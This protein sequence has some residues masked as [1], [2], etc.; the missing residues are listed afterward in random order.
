MCNTD[1]LNPRYIEEA[2]AALSALDV[3][4]WHLA[5]VDHPSPVPLARQAPPRRLVL[6]DPDHRPLAGIPLLWEG[7][8][9]D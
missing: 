9:P 8:V 6:H 3:H 5:I 7:T 2:V 4:G 1:G